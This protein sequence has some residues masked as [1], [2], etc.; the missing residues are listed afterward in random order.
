MYK[1]MCA[2]FDFD[3]FYCIGNLYTVLYTHGVTK[4]HFLKVKVF[5]NHLYG[6]TLFIPQAFSLDVG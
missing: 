4:D 6:T 3:N 1:A 2:L 5:K